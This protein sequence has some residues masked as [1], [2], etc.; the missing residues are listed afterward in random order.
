ME[1]VTNYLGNYMFTFRDLCTITHPA[2]RSFQITKWFKA[3][4]LHLKPNQDRLIPSAFNFKHRSCYGYSLIPPTYS[5]LVLKFVVGWHSL[6]NYFV[7]GRVIKID[8]D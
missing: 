7:I 8:H 3:L 2:I 1:Q 4:E 5:R 6:A